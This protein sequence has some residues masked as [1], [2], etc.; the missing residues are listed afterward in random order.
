MDK[1]DKYFF[2]GL[3]LLSLFLL[4]LSVS[5]FIKG[6]ELYSVS[7]INGASNG[8]H[9]DFLLTAFLITILVIPLAY[10]GNKSN[11]RLIKYISI[12][13]LAVTLISWLNILAILLAAIG[14]IA[15]NIA[16]IT[17]S[18]RNKNNA[19][20]S[21][22]E[23]F[24]AVI[25]LLIV[26]SF[27]IGFIHYFSLPSC[28][29]IGPAGGQC[30]NGFT[31]F[32]FTLFI[33]LELVPVLI[34]SILGIIMLIQS[35]CLFSIYNLLKKGLFSIYNLLKKELGSKPKKQ[36]VLNKSIIQTSK[37]SEFMYM[38]IEI[39]VG[40]LVAFF[41]D[42]LAAIVLIPVILISLGMS[43][44]ILSALSVFSSISSSFRI[45]GSFAVTS[46][47][48]L[49]FLALYL[50]LRIAKMWNAANSGD[51]KKLKKLNSSFW[52]IIAILSVFLAP[53]GIILL[54]MHAPIENIKRGL[55]SA[56][57]DKLTKLKKLLDDKVITKEEYNAEKNRTLGG[58]R[59]NIE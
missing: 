33:F 30:S 56:D 43:I 7:K 51:G 37:K 35:K 24:G 17:F 50:V 10:F 48:I 18:K 3:A 41:F 16:I 38:P 6:V 47:L 11:L 22:S 40:L 36:V 2:A 46:L 5:W 54:I 20:L 8:Y 53:A 26:I 1:K 31:I 14:L 28:A 23:F 15:Y 57:L 49:I 52:A 59:N 13:L 55:S 19:M 42:I 45:L 44:G 32:T 58:L 4:S 12:F 39:K 21:Y 25:N 27:F 29:A 34:F 9:S